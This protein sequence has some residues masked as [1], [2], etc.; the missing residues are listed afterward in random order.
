MANA[1]AAT[2]G[3]FRPNRYETNT[4]RVA[5]AGVVLAVSVWLL[6]FVVDPGVVQ[7][8]LGYAQRADARVPAF[9]TRFVLLLVVIASAFTLITAT[10]YYK[11]NR[12]KLAPWMFVSIGL[13]FF[14]IAHIAEA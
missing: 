2:T 4:T 8:W 7:G 3:G 12:I 5:M 11:R 6:F 10:G 1:T 9:F 14:A 13:V